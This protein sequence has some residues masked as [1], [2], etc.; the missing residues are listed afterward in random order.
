MVYPETEG[1]RPHLRIYWDKSKLSVAEAQQQLKAGDPCVETC[2]LGLSDG[3][4]EIGA[5]MLK[6]HE[7]DALVQRLSEVISNG[8]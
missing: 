7:V 8:M 2:Y 3:E 6:D 5:A 1:G 4:L